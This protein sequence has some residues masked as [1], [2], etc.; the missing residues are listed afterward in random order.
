LELPSK[1]SFTAGEAISASH[2][3][4]QRT[5]TLREIVRRAALGAR[6]VGMK[7]HRGPPG[8]G[9][10]A[11]QSADPKTEKPGKSYSTSL[12]FVNA[13]RQLL[14]RR[15][16]VEPSEPGSAIKTLPD[17]QNAPYRVVS[18]EFRQAGFTL[19]Q[20]KRA[21]NVAIYIQTKMRQP[22]VYEVVLI[23]EHEAYTAFGKEIPAGECYPSS[24][25]WGVKGFSYRTIGAAER[26]FS[27]LT[28][29]AKVVA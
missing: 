24:E 21:G 14:D 27:E 25:Q 1:G 16:G 12:G 26:K 29:D 20:L 17:N 13:D 8:N 19:T 5:I 7:S 10:G 2:Y 3:S 18:A 6:G 11:R 23:R 9:N 22:P 4:F 28:G 15:G